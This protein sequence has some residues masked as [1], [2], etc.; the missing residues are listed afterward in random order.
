MAAPSA[1]LQSA[2]LYVNLDRVRPW[3]LEHTYR[4]RLLGVLLDIDSRSYKDEGGAN[5]YLQHTDGWI[6]VQDGSNKRAALVPSSRR[7][8]PTEGKASSSFLAISRG[9]RS[10]LHLCSELTR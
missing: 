1:S 2:G 8:K 6:E 10:R 4:L 9:G 7:L 5:L 3:H